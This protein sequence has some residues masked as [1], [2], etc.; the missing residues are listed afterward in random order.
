MKSTPHEVIHIEIDREK[1]RSYLRVKWFLSWLSGLIFI[2]LPL[3]SIPIGA[4]FD[5]GAS[6]P[7][8]GKL[9]ALSYGIALP[10]TLLLSTALY[11]IFSH[12]RAAHLAETLQVTVEGAFLRIVQR[13]WTTTDR[14]IHFRSLVDYWTIDSRLQRRFGVMTLRMTTTTGAQAGFI[15]ILGVHNCEKVRDQLAELDSQRENG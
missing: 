11:F 8:V 6:L 7:A 14:K 9:A 12:N 1:L 2:G 10:A 3:A 13:G 5:R 15:D 4:A